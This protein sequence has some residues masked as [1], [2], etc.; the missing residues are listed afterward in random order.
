MTTAKGPCRPASFVTIARTDV[1][2]R[3][4]RRCGVLFPT[5]TFALFFGIVLVG[6]WALAGRPTLR[7]CWLVAASGWFYSRWDTRFVL[8]LAAAVVVSWATARAVS[9][10][11]SI[12]VR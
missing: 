1:P 3:W 10:S 5:A 12:M 2:P 4:S 11:S 6:A 9:D 7:Q 8:L